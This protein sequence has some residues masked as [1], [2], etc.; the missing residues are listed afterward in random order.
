MCIRD[1]Y[2]IYRGNITL[3]VAMN[4][5]AG[6]VFEQTQPLYDGVVNISFSEKAVG[7]TRTFIMDEASFNHTPVFFPDLVTGSGM[8]FY[9]T[10]DMLQDVV[11]TMY[12]DGCT[13]DVDVLSVTR[14][15]TVPQTTT[16]IG[17][18]TID[19]G[20]SALAPV[21]FNGTADVYLNGTAIWLFDVILPM[22]LNMTT[23]FTENLFLE[24]PEFALNGSVV[25]ATG[26]PFAAGSG[27]PWYVGTSSR[28]V[29]S[30]ARAEVGFGTGTV[31]FQYL[32]DWW[33]CTGCRVSYA[34]ADANGNSDRH[35]H[36][37]GNGNGHDNGHAVT[38]SY[39]HGNRHGNGDGHFNGNRDLL[40]RIQLQC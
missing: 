26:V 3:K 23:N 18:G 25:N 35:G 27:W 29:S 7:R 12:V 11:G 33:L 40:H 31:D 24:Q 19:I 4:D 16:T 15:W 2:K 13:G 30:G 34:H 6:V 22:G 20:G 28:L 38:F 5:T 10:M 32:I 37:D 14:N 9:L 21:E 17:D 36:G 1:R 39:A 8:D